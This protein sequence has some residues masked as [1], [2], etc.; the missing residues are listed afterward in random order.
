MRRWLST[1]SDSRLHLWTALAV[2]TAVIVIRW[3]AFVMSPE[4]LIDEGI[5]LE[6]FQ[7]VVVGEDPYAVS[8]F[9]YPRTFALVGGWLVGSF[10]ESFVRSLLRLASVAGLAILVWIAASLWTAPLSSSL[11]ASTS[12]F[13]MSQR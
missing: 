2:L 7:Q 8:G 3:W 9:Y 6:A 1:Q 10:G 12:I 11:R 13:G 4:T 5:Y